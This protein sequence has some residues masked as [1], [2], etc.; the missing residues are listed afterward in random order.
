MNVNT[1]IEFPPYNTSDFK[2]IIIVTA[3]RI[4]NI[5]YVSQYM[6]GTVEVEYFRNEAS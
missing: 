3:R 4:H 1:G 5:V 6:W 2:I